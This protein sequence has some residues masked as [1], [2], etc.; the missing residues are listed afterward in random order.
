MT[1]PRVPPG[2]GG[3]GTLNDDDVP[4]PDDVPDSADPPEHI[5][6]MLMVS[7]GA[8]HPGRE[9]LAVEM[10][11]ELSRF[12]G[13]LVAEELITGFKPVFYA[14]GQVADVI[15]FF[16]IEGHRESLDLVRRR[17]DFGRQILR[18]GAA[19]ANVRVQT[20]IAGTE[21]GRLVHTYREV[22]SEL[23]FI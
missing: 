20:L 17:G 18:M 16:L 3:E 8:V 9:G 10:F 12:L 14:D 7:F 19:T 5:S 13:K 22:R 6:G 4:F 11:T 2:E 1:Q 23:G 15:G 21:A